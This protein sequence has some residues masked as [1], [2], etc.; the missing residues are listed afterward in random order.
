MSYKVTVGNAVLEK[1]IESVQFNVS[2]LSDYIFTSRCNNKNLIKVTGNID[3]EESTVV[4]CEWALLPATNPECYKEITIEHYKEEKLLRKVT[5]SKAFVVKYSESYSN[6]KGVGTF[7]LYIKPFFGQDIEVTGEMSPLSSTA[8]PN[9]IHE[10]EEEK[11]NQ[12]DEQKH[13]TNNS[14]LSE[15]GVLS[16]TKR[17]EKQKEKSDNITIVEYGEHLTK[18]EKRRKVL[19]SNVQYT[20]PEGYTYRTDELGRIVSCEGTLKKGLAERNEYAQRI[21]GREDRLP[22]DEGGHLIA[23]IFKGSGDIDN[24][25]PMNANLN[26]GEWKKLENSWKKALDVDPPEE[27]KL[28]IKPVYKGDSQRPYKFDI[29]YKVGDDEW[30]TVT[31]NNEPGGGK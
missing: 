11:Q 17:L 26:K 6:D 13:N 3:T 10:I 14:T 8:K 30:R 1:C 21:V 12:N 25:V 15:E 20:T 27:V 24:L 9:S 28:K 2:T 19:K 31:L 18:D 7:T 5:F 23:S 29:R 22:D 16:F 4:L